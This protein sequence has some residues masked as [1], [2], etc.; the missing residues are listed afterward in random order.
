MNYLITLETFS[1]QYNA[2]IAQIVLTRFDFDTNE[3]NIINVYNILIDS[4]ESN[5]FHYDINTINWWSSQE[6]YKLNEL[7]KNQNTLFYAL[8]DIKNYIDKSDNIWCNTSFDVPI[9]LNA[10]SYCNLYSFGMYQFKDINTLCYMAGVPMYKKEH[11]Y[12]IDVEKILNILYCCY[13]KIK[14]GELK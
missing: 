3:H 11:F 14:N 9:L 2:A 10:F 6:E 4:S 13:N 8:N 1:T 12:K 5:N 7:S